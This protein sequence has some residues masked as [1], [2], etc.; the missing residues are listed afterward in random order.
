MRRRRRIEVD[1]RLRCVM[2][3]GMTSFRIAVYPGAEYLVRADRP[4]RPCRATN[5]EYLCSLE[6]EHDGEEHVAAGMPCIYGEPVYAR[7]PVDPTA[8][9]STPRILTPVEVRAAQAPHVAKEI[10][11]INAGLAMGV[12]AFEVNAPLFEEI[13]RALESAGWRAADAST[14]DGRTAFVVRSAEDE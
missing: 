9:Q 11:R 6:L 12:R 13:E 2:V 3:V 10:Q 8:A 5:G 1:V 4:D 14:R 7:W